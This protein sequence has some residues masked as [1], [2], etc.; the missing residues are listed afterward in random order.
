MTLP[1]VNDTGTTA[2]I[3]AEAGTIPT[4]SGTP[5]SEVTLPVY[6]YTSDILQVSAELLQDSA[7]NVPQLLGRL[8]GERIG[9]GQNAHFTTGTGSGQPQGFV[10]NILAGTGASEVASN[11]DGLT[12]DDLINLQHDL[13]VAYRRGGNVWW[14]MHDTTLAEVR[15][16]TVTGQGYVWQPSL[17]IGDPDRILGY[18]VMV[19]NDLDAWDGSTTSLEIIAFGDFSKFWIRDVRGMRMRRLVELYAAADQEGFVAI[20]RSGGVLLDAGTDPIVLMDTGA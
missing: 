13:D 20:L 11:S 3:D 4:D 18:P 9:R 16:I 12:G 17:Q 6:K 1:T 19:N 2:G 7:I 15:K 5:F 8:L 10:T 14:M